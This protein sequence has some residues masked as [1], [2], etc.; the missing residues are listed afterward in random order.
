MKTSISLNL[1]LLEW[2]FIKYLCVQCFLWGRVHLRLLN[3]VLIGFKYMS[4]IKALYE[5][6]CSLEAETWQKERIVMGVF[7]ND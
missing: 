3:T 5:K 7:I 1:L 6:Y 2:W 4:F